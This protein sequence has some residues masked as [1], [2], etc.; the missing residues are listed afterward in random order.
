M[1]RRHNLG[2][3][4][5]GTGS[6]VITVLSSHYL[7][8]FPSRSSSVITTNNSVIVPVW[9]HPPILKSQASPTTSCLV[10]DGWR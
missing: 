1:I 7:D 6:C 9:G 2:A 8:N 3:L 5:M 10:D 4:L